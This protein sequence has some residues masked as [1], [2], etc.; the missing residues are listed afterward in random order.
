MLPEAVT[1]ARLSLHPIRDADQTDLIELLT[2]E[3]I[4][5]TYMTPVFHC[6]A[7]KE[8]TFK[9]LQAISLSDDRFLRGIYLNGQLIGF[10]NEVEKNK[11]EIELGYVIHPRHHNHGYATEALKAVISIMS[12]SGFSVVKTGAFEGNHASMRVMEK[13]GMVRSSEEEMI[14]YRGKIHRCIYYKAETNLP[15]RA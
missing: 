9:R 13:C 14:E 5:K 4:S 12:A 10:I 7:E 8:Q 3:E 11:Q 6:E 2:N 15:A 1:T